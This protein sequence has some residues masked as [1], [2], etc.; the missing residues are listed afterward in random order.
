[1]SYR[2]IIYATNIFTN[3]DDCL[4]L[5]NRLYRSCW[6]Q[7]PLILKIVVFFNLLVLAFLLDRQSNGPVA[8]F[9]KLP[10]LYFN[11]YKK[12][13]ISTLGI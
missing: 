11:S 4:P 13:R 9:S 8:R 6:L 7:F 2:S 3:C 12:K 5:K 10:L 1:M